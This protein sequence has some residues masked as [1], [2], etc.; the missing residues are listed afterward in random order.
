MTA[1][2]SSGPSHTTA[3]SE[4]SPVTSPHAAGSPTPSTSVTAS[5]AGVPGVTLIPTMVRK[6]TSRRLTPRSPDTL[7]FF[8]SPARCSTRASARLRALDVLSAVQVVSPLRSNSWV[9]SRW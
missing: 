6:G 7:A 1:K 9:S 4:V 5:A 8:I 2:N 3:A